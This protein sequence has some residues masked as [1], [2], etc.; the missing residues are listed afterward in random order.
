MLKTFTHKIKKN[1][2]IFSLVLLIIITSLSTTFFNH[3]K[4]I[5][6][7]N[8][9]NFV[10]NIYLKKTLNYLINNLEPK[11]KKISHKVKSGETFDKILD[12]YSIDKKEIIL[13]KKN[14]IKKFNINN[15]NTKQSIEF[16]IDQTNNKIKEFVFQISNTEKIYLKRNINDDNFDQEVLSVKLDK[17]I[18]YKENIILQSLYKSATDQNIP[19]NT[20]IEFAR[21]YGFQVD[22]QRDIRKQDKFQIMYEVFLDQNKKI[23]ETGEILFA[24]L[25][26]SS[27]DNSLYYFDN[28]GSEGHYDKNGKSV[29]KALMKTPINGARLSSSFGM[30]KH[31]IDGFN[32][33]H[34]G[35][36][37]AAPMGTPIMASG[38]GIVKKAGWCG[39]GGNCVKIRH[40]S[41]YQT[42]YAH[43]S[44]FARGIKNGVRVK[45]G[46]TIG[47]VGSTGKSTGPHLHYEV[48][49]NGKKVNS[50]KLKLPSGKILKGKERRIFET[51]KIKLEVLKSEKILGIN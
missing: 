37:F 4:N 39:G 25:K 7:Q 24:N 27:Q 17:K 2:G 13:I 38:N 12:D 14:L 22:F 9:E 46:Q 16:K 49:V 29:Q 18:L 44:K 36:D 3:K 48:I 10:D 15:L 8:F 1:F 32:K 26:L 11:Y 43:M 42:V 45:Q 40:N 21:I 33:M 28:E 20:I 19:A 35:T 50:Q 51:N 30:R 47:Y 5:K 34:R 41:I 6:N 23:I 31:P